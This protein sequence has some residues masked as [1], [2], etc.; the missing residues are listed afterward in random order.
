MT[1]ISLQSENR[2]IEEKTEF[3]GKRHKACHNN[4]CKQR[5]RQKDKSL[6]KE[7]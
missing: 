2:K 6:K 7:S 5:H 3:E 1:K 4:R